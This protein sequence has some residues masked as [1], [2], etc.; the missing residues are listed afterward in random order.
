MKTKLPN[1]HITCLHEFTVLIRS[2]KRDSIVR[3]RLIRHEDRPPKLDLRWYSYTKGWGDGFA[4]N[5]Q[6]IS[7][8]RLILEKATEIINRKENTNV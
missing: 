3:T 4:L 6:S 2:T 8:L 1:T 5:H 7:R